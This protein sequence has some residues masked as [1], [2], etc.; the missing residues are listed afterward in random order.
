MSFRSRL[1]EAL[2]D[3]VVTNAEWDALAPTLAPAHRATAEASEL[4]DAWGSADRIAP[5]ACVA[6]E[7]A[8]ERR[9]YAIPSPSCS[10]RGATAAVRASNPTETD[11]TFA[12]LRTLVASAQATLAVVDDGIDVRHD[13]LT[14]HVAAQHDFID[15]DEDARG[16]QHGTHVAGIAVGNADGA[17][18]LAYR[19]IDSSAPLSAVQPVV[20]A[21]D[22]AAAAGARVINLSESVRGEGGVAQVLSAMDRHPNVLF[23]VAAG[24]QGLALD[25]ET[26][27]AFLAANRRPNMLVVGSTDA[28]GQRVP[29]SNDGASVRLLA[30]GENVFSSVWSDSYAR[31]SGTSMAAPSVSNTAIKM[32]LLDPSLTAIQLGEL[33]VRTASGRGVNRARALQ[34]VVV[35]RLMRQGLAPAVA[36]AQ[37][38][39]NPS[40]RAALARLL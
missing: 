36:I 2:A 21:I 33:L 3:R 6:I 10:A 40:E 4:L 22:A 19:A 12:R 31:L 9:G 7:D 35:R 27:A 25:A 32:V 14:Q 39:T 8:L 15:G 13:A 18:L 28:S 37:V 29:S 5:R 11:A 1:A 38:T 23:I 24:N 34:L 16:G 20:D 26:P 30:R 17:R